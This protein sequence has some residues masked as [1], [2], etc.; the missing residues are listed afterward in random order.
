LLTHPSL[1]SH[2]NKPARLKLSEV[3]LG[4]EASDAVLEQAAKVLRLLHVAELRQLQV[5]F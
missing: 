3:P 4:F 1:S 2:P 5:N